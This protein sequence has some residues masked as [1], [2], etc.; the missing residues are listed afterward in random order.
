MKL[1][2]ERAGAKRPANVASTGDDLVASLPAARPGR[3]GTSPTTMRITIE[4]EASDLVR[5]H[6][7]LKRAAR[8]VESMDEIDIVDGAKLALNNLPIGGAPAFVRKRLTAVQRLILML[9]DEAWSLGGKARREVLR[10]LVYFSDPDDLIPD[11]IEGIG[12][13]DDAIMLELLLRRLRHVLDA[14]DDFCA[15]RRAFGPPPAQLEAR[16]AHAEA[17]ARR[18]DALHLRM[19]RR[20]EREATLK[21]LARKSAPA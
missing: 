7:A 18:R 20:T 9:E 13:L 1:R 8:M 3:A 15:W 14:Y 6:Q 12:L 4:I 5:L 16:H 11:E 2:R 17:L 19:R 10:T 21:S